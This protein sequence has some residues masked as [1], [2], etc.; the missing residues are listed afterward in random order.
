ML[1]P[2]LVDFTCLRVLFSW[3][4]KEYMGDP[5]KWVSN[6]IQQKLASLPAVSSNCCIYRV[7]E[8][9]RKVNEDAYRPL[10]VSIGPF[11]YN[12]PRLVGMQQQKLRYLQSFLGRSTSYNLDY[13]TQV[14]RGWENLA[15][16]CYVE[17]IN[18]PSEHFIEMVL[19]D[20][21]FIIELFL[22]GCFH[23]F[24]DANDRVF[25]KPRMILEVTRDIRLEENQ[26]PIFI[27]KGLYD[28]VFEPS[29]QNKHLSFLDITY[30]FFMGKN[31]DIPSRIASADVRHMVDFLRL[32]YL[33]SVLRAELPT[34]NKKFEFTSSVTELSEA[35]V[36]FVAG[37]SQNLLDVRFM[38]GVLEIPRFVVTDDTE[39]LFRNI[40]VFE[41]CH[42]Y[43]DSYIIDYFAFLDSLI[44]TPKDVSILV[45]SGVIEN[46]LG[47]NEEVADLF[48]K[49]FKQTRLKGSNFYYSTICK[50]LNAYAGTPWNRWKAILK[51]D[52][53]NHPW[54]AISVIYAIVMLILTVLQVV[55]GFK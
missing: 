11:Y 2:V 53:F 6:S 4:N 54:A 9:L 13:Y 38:K 10:L 35:G 33:P 20:A 37:R 14:I 46:W 55:T 47:N 26:L 48:S 52:Y 44:N 31:E 49:L 25:N 30:R 27:L 39:S 22:R 8:N 19:L 18:L 1:I 41:Q 28:L 32:C 24:I 42:Y 40:M 5:S 3:K 21:T 45:Q 16:H 23:E 51:H 12:D 50:D 43:F 7:P 17:A 34:T 36:K 15:R 29:S